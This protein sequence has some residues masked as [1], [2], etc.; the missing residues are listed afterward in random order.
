MFVV[1]GG[2]GEI[3]IG[4]GKWVVAIVTAGISYIIL[5]RSHYYEEKLYSALIPLFVRSFQWELL[6]TVINRLSS[7]LLMVSALSLCRFMVWQQIQF[8]NAISLPRISKTTIIL[9]SDH[10][11]LFKSLSIEI[12]RLK[13]KIRVNYNFII[14]PQ[15]LRVYVILCIWVFWYIIY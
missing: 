10:L 3:F 9:I 4:L 2:L 5:T 13:P 8:S 15:T 12:L 7:A 1:V 11:L 6:L 14:P